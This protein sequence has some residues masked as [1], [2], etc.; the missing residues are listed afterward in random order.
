MRVVAVSGSLE[1]F[2]IQNP[3]CTS[4]FDPTTVLQCCKGQSWLECAWG[5]MEVGVRIH[6]SGEVC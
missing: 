5:A 3:P 2:S 4:L 6:R 1:V